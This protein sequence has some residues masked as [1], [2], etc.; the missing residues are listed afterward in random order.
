MLFVDLF[1]AYLI[2]EIILFFYD[3]KSN[4]YLRVHGEKNHTIFLPNL[5]EKLFDQNSYFLRNDTPMY[6]KSIANTYSKSI[7]DI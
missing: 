3:L 7:L 6:F 4:D 2:S 1:F 5:G